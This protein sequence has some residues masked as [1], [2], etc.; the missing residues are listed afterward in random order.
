MKDLSIIKSLKEIET[1]VIGL[2]TVTKD[3]SKSN[4]LVI[5]NTDN[6]ITCIQITPL[7]ALST[8]HINKAEGT[9]LSFEEYETLDKLKENFEDY[10]FTVNLINYN[11][12]R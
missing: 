8:L 5:D 4:W 9:F 11:I 10:Q 12:C 7:L 6:L 1:K 2:F 3:P